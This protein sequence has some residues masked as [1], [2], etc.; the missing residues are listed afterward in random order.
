MALWLTFC[1][2]SLVW[3]HFG[4][5]YC[6]VLLFSTSPSCGTELCLV[7]RKYSFFA[8][9]AGEYICLPCARFFSWHWNRPCFPGSPPYESLWRSFLHWSTSIQCSNLPS[10]ILSQTSLYQSRFVRE[11]LKNS[12]WS[13]VCLLFCW[14]V[15]SSAI[16]FLSFAV[17][18]CRQFCAHSLF[19]G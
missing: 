3:I 19:H 14:S 1:L 2:L 5:I 18:Y 7:G 9:L 13:K 11:L 16:N 15:I 12:G 17:F 6:F 4:G 10:L 8:S